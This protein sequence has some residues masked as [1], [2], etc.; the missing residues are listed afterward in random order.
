LR[1][2]NV[3]QRAERTARLKLTPAR[4]AILGLA[5]YLLV[6]LSW[7][8][9]HWLPGKQELGQAFLIPAD[10]AALCA[11]LL[12]ARRCGGSRQ[13]RSF[14][15]MMSAAMAAEMIADSFL[16]KYNIQ[17]DE[18]PF[19]TI[20]DAF[21]LSFYVLLFAALLR[22]PVAPLTRAKRLRILLDG[23]IIVLGGGAI[24]WYFVLG[25]IA[26]AGAQST[27]ALAVSLA[28]PV[29]DLILLAGLAAV[30][31]RRSPPSLRVALLLIAAGMLASIVADV[32][33][34]YGV[35]HNTYKSGDP[36]DTLYVLEFLLFALAGISQQ[37][38]GSN[39]SVAV[40]SW[41]EP[42]P[43]ASWLPYITAPIGFGLLISVAWN[44]PFFPELS[45]VLILTMIGGLVAVR[46][47]LSLRELAAAERARRES[48]RRSRAIFDN[49]GVGITVNDLRGP[50]IVEVNQA[51][52]A[53]V[54]YSPQELLGG[55]FAAL[56]HPDELSVF[57]SLTPKTIEG[58]HREIRFLR[59]DGTELWGELALSLL[60]DETGTP[61]QVIGVL[62]DITTRKQAEKVKDEFISVVGHE[63]R[64]PLTSIRGSLGLLEGGIFGELPPE[65]QSMLTLAVTN[66]DRLVR[67]INDVLDIERMDAG[68]MELQLV[69]VKASALVTSALQVLQMNATETGLALHAD[70]DEDLTVSVDTD[71]IIQV[72]VNLLGN[73]IKFSPHRSTITVTASSEQGHARF[74]IKDTGRG[75]PA[76]R[77][78]SIFER[79]RQV[80][81]SDAREKGGS[82]L[83]LAIARDIVVDHGGEMNVESEV[84]A[85]S[86]FSFTLPLTTGTDPAT[87]DS[88]RRRRERRA[89]Q[90]RAG[91]RRIEE[92]RVSERR[93]HALLQEPQKSDS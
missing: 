59:R 32:V 5:A 67:L 75:I 53:M 78:E 16:L 83:G 13:L 63:L 64:T 18:P 89:E 51:F 24:V 55:D 74:A 60:R 42:A 4:A 39:D 8:F 62:Q 80:D 33:Y 76:D 79:F 9:F 27:L 26:K 34:G 65:A 77:L 1:T 69:P 23:A 20:A 35:L 21:F 48:E 68:R 44:K 46:Q 40:S 30:L 15:W 52:S 88:D 57:N 92:R 11:T 86:T 37:S 29:G 90:R 38:V 58:F 14:W 22:V 17:Y 87:P 41:S 45:L 7:Q 84:G 31:L 72:L 47:Y 93:T 71:R 12:A 28:Y 50:V 19:P 2:A 91:E 25:P 66:T 10:M 70:V 81:S 3:D 56:T 73:A 6:Y 43:R 61:H 36:I 49:A 54:E 85:G 82:G